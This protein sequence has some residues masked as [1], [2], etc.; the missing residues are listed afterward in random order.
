MK[1]QKSGV[2][3]LDA[4]DISEVSSIESGDT[5]ETDNEWED[6]QSNLEMTLVNQSQQPRHNPFPLPEE[7]DKT[8]TESE[9]ES[10]THMQQRGMLQQEI[11]NRIQMHIQKKRRNT[12]RRENKKKMMLRQSVLNSNL[13]N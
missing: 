10:E 8:E 7:G 1:F 4:S 5:E 12:E 11:T 6:P 2:I 9:D 13:E 3:D